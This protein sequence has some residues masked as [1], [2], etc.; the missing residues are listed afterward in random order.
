MLVLLLL[1]LINLSHAH[2]HKFSAEGLEIT[3]EDLSTQSLQK[4]VGTHGRK[5]VGEINARRMFPFCITVKNST[6]HTFQLTNGGFSVKP[7]DIQYVKAHMPR[8]SVGEIFATVGMNFLGSSLIGLGE[9]L[10]KK[11]IRNLGIATLATTGVVFTWKF[12]S[13]TL[14]QSKWLDANLI[15][16][17]GV[18]IA[19]GSSATKYVFFKEDI[20]DGNGVKLLLKADH[21]KGLE[22]EIIKSRN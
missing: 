7:W 16:S 8:L 5:A 18:L 3:T 11:P 2:V 1:S 21:D 17:E 12:L 14:D 4:L 6:N 13:C 22:V 19:P 10:K 15:P 9:A 20:Y